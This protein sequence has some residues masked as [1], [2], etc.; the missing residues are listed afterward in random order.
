M[1]TYTTIIIVLLSL[2]TLFNTGC[3]KHFKIV[4][5]NQIE[6]EDRQ[7]LSFNKVDNQGEFNVYIKQD[8]IFSAR[9]VAESNLVPYIRTIVNGNTLLIDTRENMKNNQ[10]MSIYVTTPII[11]G[12]Y[13]SGSGYV[14]LDSLDTDFLEVILS[15]SGRIT[16]Y[17]KTNQLNTR[18]S[19]S[20]DIT[21]ES[22]T[23]T[24]YTTISGSGNTD[25]TGESSS[26]SFT[27]SG[28]GQISSYNFLQTD[29][30]AKI[31]GS[32]N[33]YLNVTEKLDVTISGSGSVFY[34]GNPSITVKITGSG[35]VI[36]Q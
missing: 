16:G 31:S 1:R 2:A 3:R 19:G 32:G 17:T 24:C 4:G 21:L 18:I 11:Q 26:G 15:G 36:S 6:S 20:G 34:I 7:L 5:N 9:V 8:S 29:C 23:N 12:A 33:M 13:L 14:L 25:L 30:I 35:Q 28:S 22:I 27:I 10:P